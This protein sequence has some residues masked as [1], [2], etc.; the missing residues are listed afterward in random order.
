[1]EVLGFSH[2]S[3]A[4][5]KHNLH[6]SSCVKADIE[7]TDIADRSTPAKHYEHAVTLPTPNAGFQLVLTWP[8]LNHLGWTLSCWLAA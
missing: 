7:G 1:M 3:F 8:Y 2:T 6:S 4:L 5:T